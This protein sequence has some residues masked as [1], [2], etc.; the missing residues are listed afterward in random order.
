MKQSMILVLLF[1]ALSML[2]MTVLNSQSQKIECSAS[3][4][5]A[6]LQTTTDVKT[7]LTE[8]ARRPNKTRPDRPDRNNPRWGGGRTPMAEMQLS[9]AMIEH[10]L[11]VVKEID[12]ELAGQ[13]AAICENDPEALQ[14]IIRRQGHRLGSLIRLQESDPDLFDVKV[15][16]LKIDAEIYHVANYLQS[17][18]PEDTAMQAGIAE[19]EGLVRAK[20]EITIEAQSLYIMR[21]ERHL[22]GLQS[23][24]ADTSARLEEIVQKRMDQLLKVVREDS[25]KQPDKQ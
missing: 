21:L 23:K 2:G 19:L 24:L 11:E 18:D 22:A 10:C 15:T 20:T 16:E 7:P 14:K 17:L 3:C 13:L 1:I 6:F 4:I 5:L 8:G 12:P 9:P 25:Q